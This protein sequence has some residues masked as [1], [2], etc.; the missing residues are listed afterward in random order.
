MN[1]LHV[2]AVAAS[3]VVAAATM[4]QTNVDSIHKFAWCENI[5]WTNWRDCGS[6]VGTQGG[7]IVEPY[8]SGF[9]WC[10]NVGYLNLGDGTPANG[11]WYR[12]AAGDDFGVNVLP[13]RRLSGLAWGENVGWINFGPFAALPSIQQARLDA[14]A[15]RL[16]GY[17][18]SENT[19]WVNL[20][21]PT[22][23]VGL[24]C[25]A[26]YNGDSVPDFFDYLDFVADFAAD[27]PQ[28]DFNRDNVVDFFDYLDF[29]QA[30]AAGC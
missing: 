2:S 6:P 12:N 19:G 21:D 11:S 16:R 17:A 5:G 23:F 8:L 26:D 10:E 4:A 13:D 27:L 22:H 24:I 25:P 9:V 28:A 1:R 7:R 30:F 29:V 20:D 14:S 3:L 15:G 18:W